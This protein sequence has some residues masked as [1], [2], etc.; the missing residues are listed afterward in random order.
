M[1][2][3]IVF[4]FKEESQ[5]MEGVGE[6]PDPLAKAERTFNVLHG[7]KIKR[8]QLFYRRRGVTPNNTASNLI[9]CSGEIL[10]FRKI[11]LKVPFAISE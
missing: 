6:T 9:S 5:P 10:L 4:D 3:R 2:P 7:G 8:R 11:D 1:D